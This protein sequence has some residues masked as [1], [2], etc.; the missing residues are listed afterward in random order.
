MSGR[1][2]KALDKTLKEAKFKHTQH[3]KR[4]ATQFK[5]DFADLDSTK[6]AE[7]MDPKKKHYQVDPEYPEPI[8]AKKQVLA[9]NGSYGLGPQHK[10]K[11]PNANH[12]DLVRQVVPLRP[13]YRQHRYDDKQRKAFAKRELSYWLEYVEERKRGI[14]AVQEYWIEDK[15]KVL[16]KE[17]F[18]RLRNRQTHLVA[19]KD[20]GEVHSTFGSTFKFNLPIHPRNLS[21]LIHPFQGYMIS[22]PDKS[23]SW[24]DLMQ[25]YEIHM[26]ASFEKKK[27]RYV[28]SEELAALSFWLLQDTERKGHLDLEGMRSLMMGLRFPDPET[29]TGFAKQ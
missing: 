27:G 8:D 21:Q 10:K 11:Y 28:H 15:T 3:L 7:S 6:Y 4:A 5:K 16:L 18:D 29:W 23:Y 20:L 19:A 13:L 17:A 9:I 24:D 12:F 26:L 14:S 22:M 25:T 1:L 2:T